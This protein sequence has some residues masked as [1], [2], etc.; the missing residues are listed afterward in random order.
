MPSSGEQNFLNFFAVALRPQPMGSYF[1]GGQLLRP[2]RME[3]LFYLK[4]CMGFRNNLESLSSSA[5]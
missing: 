2:L 1:A 4:G 3:D 5:I